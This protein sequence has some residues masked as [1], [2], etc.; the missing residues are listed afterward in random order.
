VNVSVIVAT[1]GDLCWERLAEERAIPSAEGQGAREVITLHGVDATL[2]E[3]RNEA[4][5][6]ASGDWLCGL[7]ADDELAPGYLAAMRA[8]WE[9]PF[10]EQLERAVREPI[11]DPGPSPVISSPIEIPSLLVPAVQYVA[12]YPASGTFA[13]APE[14]PA[15]GLPL[16]DVN[17][18]SIGTL[19]P[20][21]L[22]LEVG[23]FR[24]TLTDGTPLSALE[25]WDLALRLVV[26]G[27]RLVPVP[28]AVYRAFLRA[29]SRNADQSL[30]GAIRREHL[31]AY[32]ALPFV[33]AGASA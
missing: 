9:T 1:H 17:C 26:A 32:R 15:W 29:G 2:A 20:R 11:L 16:I 28:A 6:Q 25:D 33:R 10:E 31:A 30:Y 23:G 7:D 18:C 14:I 22:F 24:D 12:P 4:A 19:I 21:R 3:V 5:R 13:S 27:A 8:Y